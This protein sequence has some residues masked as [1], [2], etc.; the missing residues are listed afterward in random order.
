MTDTLKTRL[1]ATY[2][3]MPTLGG[4]SI[5]A[6]GKTT[7]Y[8]VSAAQVPINPDGREAVARIEYLEKRLEVQPEWGEDCDGIGCRDETIRLQDE[9]MARQSAHIEALEAALRDSLIMIGRLK[10]HCQI[11][12]GAGYTPDG[13]MLRLTD[14]EEAART[15]L[16]KRD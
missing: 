6:D 1:L 11:T 12:D 8:K 14:V 2:S 13:R 7:S 4:G 5:S 9:R 16:E 3:A 15:L 10:K